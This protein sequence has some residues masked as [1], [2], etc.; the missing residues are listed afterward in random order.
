MTQ[1][2][3]GYIPIENYKCDKPK[4]CE[5]PRHEGRGI[6]AYAVMAV[7]GCGYEG[8]VQ[9]VCYE[10][11]ARFDSDMGSPDWNLMKGER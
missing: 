2:R 3:I 4:V 5:A 8:L 9:M 10:C 1:A 6:D 11:W 7:D